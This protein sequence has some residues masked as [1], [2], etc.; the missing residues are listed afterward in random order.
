MHNGF[1]TVLAVC[2]A[3][4]TG[5]GPALA[6][7]LDSRMDN[8]KQDIAACQG[9]DA[10]R[11]INGCTNLIRT[12]PDTVGAATTEGGISV[13]SSI[14][15]NPVIADAYITRALNYLKKKQLDDAINDC[16]RVIRFLPTHAACY[17]IR[18]AALVSK[19]LDDNALVDAEKGVSLAPNN[20]DMLATRGQVYEKIG[21]TEE[22][23]ADYRKATQI[24]PNQVSAQQGLVRLRAP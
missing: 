15:T 5:F 1:E 24:N 16:S 10:D 9:D 4:T 6:Q 21:A 19:N 13:A 18:A 12:A 2:A 17:G 14:A 11:A 23:I 20:A 8:N 3:L 22:A 7:R